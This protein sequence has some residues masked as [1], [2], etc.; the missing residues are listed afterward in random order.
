MKK[1]I[2]LICGTF[3]LVLSFWTLYYAYTPKVGQIGNG[4][5]DK[6]VWLQ[7]ITQFLSGISAL[8]LAFNMR[9]N[10]KIN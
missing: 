5:N 9:K 10:S 3:L 1:W 7:S 4:P 6:L 8:F 2:L